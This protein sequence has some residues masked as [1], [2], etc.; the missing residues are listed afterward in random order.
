MTAS[1]E[2]GSAEKQPGSIR[3]GIQK[4]GS[5]M[6]GMIM[7]IIPA[8]I[9]WGIITAIV[10]NI[11]ESDVEW[12]PATAMD[13]MI[14]PMIHYLLP[15]LIAVQGG[16][17][18]YD[19]RGA[20]VG[21]VATMGVIAGSD[22][23]LG[24][25]EDGEVHMFI[26]AMILGPLAA[27]LM[28]KLDALWEGKI[29]AGFEMLVNMFSAGILA[30][31]I[32][33]AA[34]FTLAPLVNRL[35]EVLGAAVEFLVET[36]LLPL[37]SVLIEP[38]KVFFLNNAVNHGVLTPL[39]IGEASETGQSVLFLLE[40]NPGVGLGLL[41]A[42]SVFGVGAARATAPGAALIVFFGGI[43]EVYFPYVLM[44]PALLLAVI[45]GGASGVA[46]NLFLET[47]LRGPAA[48]G[49]IIAV[50]AQAASG[51]LWGI[52][53]AWILSAAVTFAVAS[54]ILLAGRKRD[55]EG[56]DQFTSA[57]AKTAAAKGKS[58]DHLANL[59]SAAGGVP[60]SAARPISTIYFACDA[61]MG[62]SAMGASVLRKKIKGAGIQDVA[63]S[64]KAIASLPGD[65]DL[66][67]TQQQLT[68]R[69]RA[70]EPDAVHVSVD[71]FMDAPEYDEVVELVKTSAEQ[72]SGGSGAE[73]AG[74]MAAG[75]ETQPGPSVLTEDRVR[76]R[77]G[78]VTQDQALQEAAQML[79]D[80]GTV[81][82]D[83]LQAMR[84]REAT[85]STYMGNGL[86]IPHGTNEAKDAV[87]ASA[88]CMVRYDG[89]VDWDG[90][91]AVFV[92]GIA[93]VGDEHLEILTRIA[94]IFA[95]E[96]QVERLKQ[97]SSEQELF[98]LLSA[99]NEED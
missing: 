61:G 62:S 66:V 95:D 36:G 91:Q 31:L 34:F 68:A 84:D 58:S 13:T 98:E 46:T 57:V 29:R 99:V 15:L 6:S 72:T 7:P 25:G 94:Q 64:N 48:P 90:D 76:L 26:G 9:A 50:Y 19:M 30:F 11:A 82:E 88:L 24:M 56:E 89:G 8:L 54:L 4:V 43:H 92:I 49:S 63:V 45:A 21:A 22:W 70:Q 17:M 51:S 77:S 18:V 85:V 75:A 10:V 74:D 80:A 35:M 67:I 86:A 69:A 79:E 1:A 52:T 83:Y 53:L 27:W 73:V 2:A 41:V 42:F 20:V 60:A 28:K 3:V 44:K 38:A 23:D 87:R 40:A 5:F 55:L 81:T 71:S 78:S 12:G 14:F 93:G 96:A 59:A 47:G 97:A 37:T 32:A 33:V 39:G 16:K 65:A